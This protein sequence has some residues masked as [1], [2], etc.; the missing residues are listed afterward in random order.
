MTSTE[1]AGLEL[2]AANARALVQAGRLRELIG[3]APDAS[4]EE[5]KAACKRALLT[6]HPDKGGNAEIFKVIQPALQQGAILRL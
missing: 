2:T 5:M 3:V 1:M 4:P 6:H